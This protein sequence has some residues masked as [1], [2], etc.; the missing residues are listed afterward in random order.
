MSIFDSTPSSCAAYF[1][2]GGVDLGKTPIEYAERAYR[3]STFCTSQAREAS[4]DLAESKKDFT[5]LRK[6]LKLDELC[7]QRQALKTQWRILFDVD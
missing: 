4:M 3:I 6:L 5:L 1:D 2:M 7:Q